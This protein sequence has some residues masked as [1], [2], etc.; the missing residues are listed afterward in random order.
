MTVDGGRLSL[1]CALGSWRRRRRRYVA[2][3]GSEYFRL[4]AFSGETH[5]S[6]VTSEMLHG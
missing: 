6:Y 4:L 3:W 1:G 2:L 5:V